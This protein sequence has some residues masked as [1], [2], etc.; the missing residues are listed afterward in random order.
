MAGYP[1]GCLCERPAMN[2]L[3]TPGPQDPAPLSG[4]EKK[5]LSQMER[6][7]TSTDPDLVRLSTTVG[8]GPRSPGRSMNLTLQVIA[9]LVIALAILPA[10][11]LAVLAIIAVMPGLPLALIL[12]VWRESDNTTRNSDRHD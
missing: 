2:T 11:W 3:P 6:S 9:I 7:L 12:T 4:R 10:Q 1:H 8:R 5:I